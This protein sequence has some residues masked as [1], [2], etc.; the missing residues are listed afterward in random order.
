MPN[1]VGKTKHIPAPEGDGEAG[2]NNHSPRVIVC[3]DALD[4][5][6][7]V[8]PHA[9]TIASSLGG[10]LMLVHVMEPE[11]LPHAPSDP[12]E[13]DLRRRE[14]QTFISGLASQ[15]ESNEVALST[16]I[17]EGLAAEQICS[18][19]HG[20]AGDITALYRS[21]DKNHCRIGGTA[22]RVMEKTS[23]SIL[24]VPAGVPTVKKAK[25][26]RIMVPLDGSSRAESAVPYAV[27]IAAAENAELLLAHAT[28]QLELLHVGPLSAEDIDLR[29]RLSRRNKKAAGE[30]L[31]RLRAQLADCGIAVR[32]LILNKGDVRR[33]LVGSIVDQSVDLLV[34]SAYGHS[35]FADVPS[36]NVSS[37]M[38]TRSSVPVLMLRPPQGIGSEHIFSD[39]RS[40]GVRH[41]SGSVK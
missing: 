31:G 19:V 5:S 14:A 16:K 21:D 11:K 9:Y 24:M 4:L 20:V 30:Y 22:R 36:G 33:Q 15:L 37:F 34:L 40:K 7:K 10:E 32:T 29:E 6:A 8:I 26:A 39:T 1:N 18:C 38:M 3:V 23:S 12:V 41:L 13:W 17:L 28:P 35:G 2:A 25:Y 27:R